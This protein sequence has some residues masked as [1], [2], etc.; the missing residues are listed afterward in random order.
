M[1]CRLFN[2]KASLF[3][4]VIAAF[5]MAAIA[6]GSQPAAPAPAPAQ[7]A[8]DPAELSKLVQDAVKQSVP[9]QQAGP[10]PVSASE[11][12][13]MV[14]AA[15][16]AAAPEGA[17]PEEISAMVQQAVTASAQ[18]GVS[19]GRR[20]GSCHQGRERCRGSEPAGC[21]GR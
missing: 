18:P 7:P 11:I 10:A 9:E 15:V 3:V 2:V 19:K 1:I 21:V 6:C 20:G 16:Q 12:Q 8:I 5:A 17:S 14:E 4:F 13:A